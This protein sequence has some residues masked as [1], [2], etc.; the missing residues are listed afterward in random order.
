MPG[1]VASQGEGASEAVIASVSAKSGSYGQPFSQGSIRLADL[2]A[3][4]S[5]GEAA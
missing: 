5:L 1:S 2:T 3:K 4:G